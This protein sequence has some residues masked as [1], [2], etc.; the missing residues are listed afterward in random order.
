MPLI[1]SIGI[2]TYIGKVLT[3][4]AIGTGAMTVSNVNDSYFW[5]VSKYSA[6]ELKNVL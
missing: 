4:I 2:T 5:L 3:I 1:I 6:L